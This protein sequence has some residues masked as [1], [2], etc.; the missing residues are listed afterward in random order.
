MIYLNDENF[1]FAIM[2]TAMVIAFF[3]AA[4]LL[5]I[6][7]NARRQFKYDQED[8]REFLDD[9]RKQISSYL[10]HTESSRM[11]EAEVNRD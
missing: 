7:R 9:I 3:T 5:V 4:V 11:T 10:Q 6:L 2:A 8:A 1:A